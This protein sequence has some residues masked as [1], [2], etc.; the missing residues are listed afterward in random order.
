MTRFYACTVL[1]AVALAVAAGRNGPARAEEFRVDN[2]VYADDQKEPT[3]QSTTIFH[4]GVVYDCLK[5]PAETV[6]FD[7]AAGRFV[8]LNLNRRTRTELTTA[9][10]SEFIDG[11][12][13]LAAKHADAVKRFLADPKFDERWDETANELTFSSPMVKYRLVLAQES[14]SGIVEQYREFCDWI[15]RLRPLLA[16]NSLPPFGRLMVNAAVAKRQA[17]ATRVVLTI[18]TT[19]GIKQQRTTIR[20]EHRL[21]PLLEPADLQQVAKAREAM[22][23][24]KPVSFE[25]YRKSEPR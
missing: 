4:E 7:K 9:K 6:V 22:S 11:L 8:L 25:Q 17:T 20:S 3:S 13:P 18:T 24:F 23:S 15:A 14:N 21:V 10:L 2:T 5:T 1:L 12:Q 19:K 16:P